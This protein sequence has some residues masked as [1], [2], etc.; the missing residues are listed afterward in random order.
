MDFL[1]TVLAGLAGGL[2]LNALA[3]SP[4][5]PRQQQVLAPPAAPG[6]A[7]QAGAR[8]PDYEAS[9]AANRRR[10]TGGGPT[11]TPSSTFLTGP[12]GV[13]PSKLVL[14]RNTLLGA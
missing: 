9:L 5:Q 2:L 7:P 10:E 6:Q 13:D 14:G 1:Y 11:A 4:Q 8:A 3:P 12:G